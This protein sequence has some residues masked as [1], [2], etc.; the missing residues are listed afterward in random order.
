MTMMKHISSEANRGH[1]AATVAPQ[2]SPILPIITGTRIV[3]QCPLSPTLRRVYDSVHDS[4][5]HVRTAQWGCVTQYGEYAV[6]EI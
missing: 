6:V 1:I 2:C 3:S 4:T 5:Q